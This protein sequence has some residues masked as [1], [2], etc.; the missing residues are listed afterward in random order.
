MSSKALALFLYAFLQTGDPSK[1]NATDPPEHGIDFVVREIKRPDRL[2]G[3]FQ[4]TITFVL[5]E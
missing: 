4:V 3:S 1:A 5:P 2:P